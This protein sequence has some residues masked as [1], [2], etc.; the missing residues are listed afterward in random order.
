MSPKLTWRE[1]TVIKILLLVAKI[2]ADNTQLSDEIQTLAN[3]IGAGF[4]EGTE[5]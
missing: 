3:H 2:V 1:K 4:G 5:P